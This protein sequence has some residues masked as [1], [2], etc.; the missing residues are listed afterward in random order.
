MS[1]TLVTGATGFVGHALVHRLA[2][3]GHPI[4]AAT[5]FPVN[6]FPVGVQSIA[7]GD[8]SESTDWST[9]LE[10]VSSVVHCAA[11]AH[12]LRDT[13]SDPLEQFRAVNTRAA[14][15][16]AREA[17]NAGV[18]R[19]VFISS[20]GVNGGET[21]GR[22]FRH[23]DTPQPHTP[24]ATSKYEAE[25]G[26]AKV[27]A[28]TGLEVVIIR[29]PLVIGPHPKGNLATLN[30]MIG[31]GLPLPFGAVT[32]NRRDLVSLDNL[33]SLIA[34]ALDHPEAA[35]QTFLASDGEP[36]STKALVQRL[37][38]DSGRQAALVPVPAPILAAG[39]RVAGKRA[40]ASQLLGDLEVDISHTRQT[41]GWEPVAT[42]R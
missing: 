16:L 4:R 36:I 30:R 29:P 20:I 2:D 24:Y 8:I 22:P 32:R 9:A 12:V 19:L 31:T 42:S 23:D 18:R 7:V 34:V 3:Q 1:R 28:E 25:Q 40:M 39:L 26:L 10:N 17:A 15:H 13:A 21:A 27:A 37:A 14:I 11:R 5:R 41:L 35:G 38:A 6:G 33:C